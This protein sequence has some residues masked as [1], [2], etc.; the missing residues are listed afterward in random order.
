VPSEVVAVAAA[1]VAAVFVEAV[2]MTELVVEV[3]T[4]VVVAVAVAVAVAAAGGV[5]GVAAVAVAAPQGS[6]S[7]AGAYDLEGIGHFLVML[8]ADNPVSHTLT[9][10]ICQEKSVAYLFTRRGA[11]PFSALWHGQLRLHRLRHR[12]PI[13]QLSMGVDSRRARNTTILWILSLPRRMD[14][15]VLPTEFRYAT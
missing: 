4:V 6:A 13:W 10:T 11:I 8:G 7:Y 3:E 9:D 5:A 15:N 14:Y 12:P 2:V 1:V